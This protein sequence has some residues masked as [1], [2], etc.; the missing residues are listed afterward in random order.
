MLDNNKNRASVAETSSTSGDN[1]T[2]LTLSER[3]TMEI[4]AVFCSE[5]GTWEA[6]PKDI[7][8]FLPT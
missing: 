6:R 1:R 4:A 7:D 8:I 5:K 2:T 3:D